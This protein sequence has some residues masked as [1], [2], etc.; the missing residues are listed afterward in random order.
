[1]FG[2]VYKITNSVNGKIYVGQTIRNLER[3]FKEHCIKEG[4]PIFF[5]AIKKYGK[6]NFNT[7]VIEECRDTDEL[8]EKEI[9]W[10][11]KLNS[12][13][14]SG[15]NI[16]KGGSGS[17]G[18]S[19]STDHKR[20]IAKS[21]YGRVVSKSTREKLRKSKVGK[22]RPK[23]VKEAIARKLSKSYWFLDPSNTKI[24]VTNL[25]KFCRENNL[26]QSSMWKVSSGNKKS[27]KGYTYAMS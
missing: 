21:L 15:Y 1:M 27:Y 25:R 24:K 13:C 23:Y 18:Y 6:E 19:L 14:P 10:I 4:C 26:D 17:S 3:R 16:S 9:Y 8:N 12:Q 2:M 20:K 7:E 5:K 22:S 11:Q